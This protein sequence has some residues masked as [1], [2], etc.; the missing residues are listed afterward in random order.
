MEQETKPRSIFIQVIKPFVLIPNIPFIILVF[1]ALLYNVY[2][3]E[4]P[5]DRES[6]TGYLKII[7]PRHLFYGIGL[8]FYVWLG[9]NII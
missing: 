3:H 2:R 1:S 7:Y 6:L 4:S 9:V 8:I 5:V